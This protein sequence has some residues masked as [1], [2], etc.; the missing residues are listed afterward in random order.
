MALPMPRLAPVTRATWLVMALVPITGDSSH[1]N[2]GGSNWNV[3]VSRGDLDAVFVVCNL[4]ISEF[5]VSD[6]AWGRAS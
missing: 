4:R 1:G 5:P 6:G 3:R 2:A